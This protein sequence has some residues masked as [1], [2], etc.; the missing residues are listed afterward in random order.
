MI[1][2]TPA[3]CGS[4]YE[5]RLTF[6]IK[7]KPDGQYFLRVDGE[8][9][10]DF[11]YRLIIKYR[12]PSSGPVYKTFDFLPEFKN[13]NDTPTET[14]NGDD[15]TVNTSAP[16][17]KYGVI[18]GN[19]VEIPGNIEDKPVPHEP[20]KAS[21]GKSKNLPAEVSA[22][23]AKKVG[24]TKRDKSDASA[25]RVAKAKRQTN[26]AAAPELLIKKEGSYADEIIA[27]QKEN[28]AIGQ[29]IA[30]LEKQIALLKEVERL[31]TRPGAASAPAVTL[32]MTPALHI[33]A[34][35]PVAVSAP[36]AS[37]VKIP[38]QITQQ[39]DAGST[40]VLRWSLIAVILL[41]LALLWFL[42]R[43]Q[44]NLLR[45]YSLAEFKSAMVSP[46]SNDDSKYLD[47][48]NEFPKK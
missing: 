4:V 11:F 39:P 2:S 16:S 24:H 33:P 37:P 41:L 18:M 28:D 48:I 8:R 32:E 7:K 47:L 1:G 34:S 10:E 17:G 12:S 20:A 26:K 30:M 25:K 15:V 29:Q 23:D 31:K 14:S 19:V 35:S 3:G 27:L 44:K 38:A 6:F 36:A 40:T 22:T 45:Q 42:Y 46:T 21:P 9:S 5:K 13:S 43:R